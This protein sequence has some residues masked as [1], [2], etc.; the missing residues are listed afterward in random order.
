MK[1]TMKKKNLI[2]IAH[3]DDEAIFFGN[4]LS[5]EGQSSHVICVTDAN[6]DGHGDL[7]KKEFLRSMK[8]FKVD[9]FTWVSLP[10]QYNN[11]LDQF[12]LLDSLNTGLDLC[13]KSAN[14]Y[15]HGLTGEYG[16]P[17]HL[18]ISNFVH[19]NY[20][21]SYKVYH[22][23]YFQLNLTAQDKYFLRDI[24]NTKTKVLTKVYS[25]EYMK[26]GNLLPNLEKESFIRSEAV[27]LEVSSYLLIKRK[28]LPSNLGRYQFLK[29]HF[30]LLREI[31]SLE[32]P[33]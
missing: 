13:V 16:H 33:F 17:H 3:P 31:G 18:Q 10:D 25:S 1:V 27:V 12:A 8:A 19:Q 15:T 23:N 2:I 22:P 5:H 14:I 24:K 21:G 7:R 26:F 4:L 11:I 28:T 29:P 9:S 6:A 32:R 20:F 30:Q